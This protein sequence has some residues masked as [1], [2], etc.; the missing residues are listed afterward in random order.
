[1]RHRWH[2]F[3]DSLDSNGG[4]IFILMLLIVGGMLA[5]RFNIMNAQDI[6][7]GAF[8]ALL[9]ALKNAASNQ[10]RREGREEVP[11]KENMP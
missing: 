9:L 5:V 10:S 3:L 4:H 8:G 6:V 11:T 1:M 2:D 7:Q